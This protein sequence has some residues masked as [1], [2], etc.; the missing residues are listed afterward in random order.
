ML[1]EKRRCTCRN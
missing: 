1:I